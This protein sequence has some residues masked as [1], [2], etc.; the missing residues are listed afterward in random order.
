MTD[1]YS[2][3]GQ[4]PLD[5]DTTSSPK[6][7]HQNGDQLDPPDIQTSAETARRCG[8]M[9][10][11][12][13]SHQNVLHTS[14]LQ[15]PPNNLT[16]PQFLRNTNDQNSATLDTRLLQRPLDPRTLETRFIDSRALDSRNLDSREHQKE[17]A[18]RMLCET[19]PVLLQDRSATLDRQ[20]RGA[21][22]NTTIPSQFHQLSQQD[23][24]RSQLTITQT[25]GNT[26][27]VTPETMVP[28]HSLTDLGVLS[29]HD[30]EGG[31]NEALN[32]LAP[33]K[34][35]NGSSRPY[36]MP[37]SGSINIR[38]AHRSPSRALDS[39]KAES[40]RFWSHCG[41]CKVFISM[42]MC[43]VIF[44]AVVVALYFIIRCRLSV[45]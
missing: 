2:L 29:Y 28:L 20:G 32:S 13:K 33:G 16:E 5:F 4:A 19:S 3:H 41:C 45:I 25:G 11:R 30:E 12:R 34:H 31:S 23:I 9:D 22:F 36:G 15:H 38:L 35:P 39:T 17:M 10:R 37:P 8:S 1:A 42:L 40:G 21:S 44:A 6:T 27:P 24:F 14:T 18:Q 26:Q 43:F 7:S